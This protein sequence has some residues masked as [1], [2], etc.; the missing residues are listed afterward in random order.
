MKI[1]NTAAVHITD[2]FTE[3][4][5][6]DKTN[7]ESYI[8]CFEYAID[9]ILFPLTLIFL[10]FIFNKFIPSVIFCAILIPLKMLAG[11]AHASTRIKCSIISYGISVVT[12]LNYNTLHIFPLTLLIICYILCFG[13][14][15]FLAPVDH[16]NNKFSTETKHKLQKYCFIYLC[17]LSIIY[18]LFV[19]NDL[20]QYYLMINACT[21]IVAANQIIGKFT[22]YR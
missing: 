5:I 16:K 9:M 8:Y 20:P 2:Y 22:N 1:S 12:L 15:T 10:G 21:L 13:T 18:I 3:T 14:I 6:I 19:Y 4:G 17:M 7:K 11:G